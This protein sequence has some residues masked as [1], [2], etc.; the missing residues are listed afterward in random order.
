MSQREE[1]L[2]LSPCFSCPLYFAAHLGNSDALDK[3]IQCPSS[4]ADNPRYQPMTYYVNEY[5][6]RCNLRILEVTPFVFQ[7]TLHP[8]GENPYYNEDAGTS[9]Y[10]YDRDEKEEAIHEIIRK[11]SQGIEPHLWSNIWTDTIRQL[12]SQALQGYKEEAMKKAR[13]I[14]RYNE[15]IHSY[16]V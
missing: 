6:G 2:L 7:F 12:H 16:S 11:V 10:Q 8:K 1:R 13:S 9:F 14:E 15:L 4:L 5:N 3:C